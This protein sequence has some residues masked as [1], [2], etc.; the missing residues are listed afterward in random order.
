MPKRVAVGTVMGDKTLKTRRVE[1]RRLVERQ[2]QARSHRKTVCHVHDENNES[3]LGDLVE[4]IE[5]RPRSRTKSWELVRV[6]TESQQW[7][8]A[9]MRA[10]QQRR[11]AGGLRQRAERET[12]FAANRRLAV[13]DF[14]S[15][16]G[17]AIVRATMIQMQTRLDVADNTGA[18][19][20]YCIKVLGGSRRR[21]AG[22]AT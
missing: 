2:V 17:R 11:E 22:S 9:A 21:R 6:V 4:I 3:G 10:A 20:L 15:D 8:I 18:K 7:S 19:E 5:C 13:A 14:T 12:T 1:I 16:N